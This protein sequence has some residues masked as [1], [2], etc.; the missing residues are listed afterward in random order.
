MIV[1]IQ[2]V[3]G[4]SLAYYKVTFVIQVAAH[5]LSKKIIYFVPPA[6]QSLILPTSHFNMVSHMGNVL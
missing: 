4:L 5:A 1:Q 3:F 2:I 6:L